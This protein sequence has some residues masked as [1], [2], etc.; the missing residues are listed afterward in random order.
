MGTLHLA[1]APANTPSPLLIDIYYHIIGEPVERGELSVVH[2]PSELQHADFLAKP[3]HQGLFCVHRKFSTN[4]STFVVS[5]L[6]C[7]VVPFLLLH[8]SRD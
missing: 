7:C 2:L 1:N 6:C 3:L 8:E 5:M 4:L